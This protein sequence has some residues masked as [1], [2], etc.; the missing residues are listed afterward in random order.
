MKRLSMEKIKEILKMREGGFSYRDIAASV[1]CS[2]SVVGYTIN[3]AE[4]ANLQEVHE[5]SETELE[6][7]LFPEE[8]KT[9]EIKEP[10]MMYLIAELTKKHVTRQLLW[11][12]YKQENKDGLMYSQFCE[13]IRIALK[14]NE[15]AYHKNHKA[16]ED[17][18]VD[19]A[20]TTIPYYCAD[21]REWKNAIIFVGVLPASVYPYVRAYSDQ[22]T[23]SW[24]DAHVRMFKFFGGT[25]RI[26]V[27]DCT[28]TAVTSPDLF[29]PVIT[30]TYQE[31]ASHYDIT[32]IPA[33]PRKPQDKNYVE[34][35]VGNVSRR[36][37]AALRNEHF[38]SIASINGAIEQKLTEFINEPFKKMNG[39]RLSAFEQIDKPALRP[40]PV[41]H[42]EFATFSTGRI[43]PNYHVEFHG[44]FYSVPYE[45]RSNEYK[46]R[47]TKD[48]IEV[49][50]RGERVC[51]HMRSYSGNRYVTNPDHLPEQHK[52]LSDW[53]DAYFLELAGKFGENTTAYIQALMDRSEYSVQA[54]R[55]CM[56]VLRQTNGIPTEI[57]ETA[58]KMALANGFFTGKYFSIVLNKVKNTAPSQMQPVVEHGN[59]R[60]A[61]AFSGGAKHA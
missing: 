12:E 32:I 37:I 23:A 4:V 21:K 3:R 14:E 13:K 29:N 60:G 53:N 42:Y 2:K 38:T 31:M 50:V 30:K 56:G 52:V 45:L 11:E 10:D 49:F 27:P 24:I 34:N 1:G 15:L 58:S 22:K 43:P 5:Y 48:A 61:S 36:I 26:L 16:G 59:I 57:V 51:A 17:C 18:E 44:F 35:S 9:K 20:G 6:A 19:W 41:S 28:K 55:A 46:V 8:E 40:L 25:P 39:C 54:Y 33:R 47:A 7:I